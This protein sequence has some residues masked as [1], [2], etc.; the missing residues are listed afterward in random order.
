MDSVRGWAGEALGAI[1][2]S[3]TLSLTAGLAG[4]QLKLATTGRTKY[5]TTGLTSAC[6]GGNL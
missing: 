1:Q 3:I 2:L 5:L 4:I 6:G